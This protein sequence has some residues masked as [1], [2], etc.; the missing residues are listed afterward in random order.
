MI[1][2]NDGHAESIKPETIA[3]IGKV[4]SMWAHIE[5]A[6]TIILAEL[7]EIKVETAF[8]LSAALDYRHHRDL[9]NSLADLK[10]RDTELGVKLREFMAQVKGMNIERNK[11]VHAL[12]IVNPETGH[13]TRLTIRNQ[14]EFK[15]E[16]HSVG[17]KHLGNIARQ[18]GDLSY[19]GV[20]LG[21]EIREA[22]AAWRQKSEPLDWP[23]AALVNAGRNPPAMP[24][25]P[26]DPPP[27]STQ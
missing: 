6:L 25:K 20:N 26:A 24:H 2:Q 3:M 9:I 17:W 22:V 23:P 4:T 7:M 15:M 12:W 19:E 27:S 13:D 8:V 18:I 14:G 16:F 21:H 10:L 5:L 11:A 1:P